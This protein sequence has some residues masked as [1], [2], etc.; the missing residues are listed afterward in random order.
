MSIDINDEDWIQGI[1]LH[2][3]PVLTL[4][5]IDFFESHYY[6]W[7]VVQLWIKHKLGIKKFG[8]NKYKELSKEKNR[9]RQKDR[10]FLHK[11]LPESMFIGA[12][13]QHWWYPNQSPNYEYLCIWTKYENQ[14]IELRALKKLGWDV[15][16]IC[17]EFEEAIE[18]GY[19]N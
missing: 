1:P 8:Y 10:Y 9:R 6:S 14:V 2:P 3:T 11:Y 7:V 13:V 19:K 16:R 15:E 5:E 17:K 4:K 18:N 12:E